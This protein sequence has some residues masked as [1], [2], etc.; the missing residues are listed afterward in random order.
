MWI[1]PIIESWDDGKTWEQLDEVRA[2]SAEGAHK[3]ALKRIREE[4]SG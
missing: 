2:A 3:E 1:L 4:A